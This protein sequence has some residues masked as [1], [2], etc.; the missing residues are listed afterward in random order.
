MANRKIPI[1]NQLRIDLSG[2]VFSFAYCSLH[3]QRTV[4]RAPARKPL[5][6]AR[7]K[8]NAWASLDKHAHRWK[9][10]PLTHKSVALGTG[11]RIKM[12]IF[13]RFP[14]AIVL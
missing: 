12:L 4:G 6:F 13:L 9:M 7:L 8:F 3:E 14:P 5:I 2:K 11:L 1:E 10:S